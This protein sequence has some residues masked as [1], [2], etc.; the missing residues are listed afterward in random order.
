[1]VAT[2]S[3]DSTAKLWDVKTGKVLHT[4]KVSLDPRSWTELIRWHT[5]LL[6]LQIVQ[7]NLFGYT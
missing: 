4:F 2:G 5:W 6:E 3:N 7:H 1:M